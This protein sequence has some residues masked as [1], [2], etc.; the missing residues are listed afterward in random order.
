MKP[1]DRDL[2]AGTAGSGESGFPEYGVAGL[3]RLARKIVEDEIGLVW[4][5]AEVGTVSRPRSGH[6]YFT[7]KDEE[8]DA[9]VDAVMWRGPGMRYG[10]IIKEGAR[11]RCLGRVTIYE[12]RGRY[13]VVIERAEASGLGELHIAFEKLKKKLEV[14]GLFDPGKKSPL[15]GFPSCIGVVTSS[16]GAA[17][18]DITRILVRR[19]PVRIL[20]SGAM[21]QGAGAAEDLAGAL[22]R[23]DETGLADVIILGRGGG[24]L[25]DLW[26][27]NEEVLARAVF[28][29]R[30]PVVSAVGHETDFTITDFVADVRAATPSEAAEITAPEYEEVI[31]RVSM[32]RRRLGRAF[33]AVLREHRL[34]LESFRQ[35]VSDPRRLVQEAWLKVE[36]MDSRRHRAAASFVYSCSRRLSGMK[37]RLAAC[38]PG[39]RVMR[40]ASLQG[41]L[42]ARMKNV[43]SIYIAVRRS[44]CEQFGAGLK[45]L[46]PQ[47]ILGRGYS[48]VV[49]TSD[50]SVVK[51]SEDA[52]PES[53]VDLLLH[54]GRLRARVSEILSPRNGKENLN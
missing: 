8:S 14:E 35:R 33:F 47:A 32:L 22:K 11:L 12:A 36:E 48:I 46:D 34:E 18:S 27:F 40:G 39:M 49:R 28:R 23:L 38:H 41:R 1:V 10:K 30:T 13:Q 50:G 42:N 54:R 6:I 4:V 37:A 7:L 29:C 26:A 2:M 17:F 45:A 53:S 16:S 5:K 20:L 24:S 52:P 31:E 25:E 9:A 51:S 19:F 15:P 44:R 43:I 21:V 3:N